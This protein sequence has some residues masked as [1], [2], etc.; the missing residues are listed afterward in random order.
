MKGWVGLVGRSIADS[1][2]TCTRS[3]GG[4]GKL[5]GQRWALFRCVPCMHANNQPMLFRIYPCIV[6]R[7][8]VKAPSSSVSETQKYL[9]STSLGRPFRD[10]Y[11]MEWV[12]NA[13]ITSPIGAPEVVRHDVTRV[14]LRIFLNWR[15]FTLV[16]TDMTKRIQNKYYC[17]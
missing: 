16:L 14:G 3:S 13:T 2:L 7:L 17:N 12:Q 8:G 4:Q 15:N 9:F 10:F 5:A 6:L 1:L 11:W